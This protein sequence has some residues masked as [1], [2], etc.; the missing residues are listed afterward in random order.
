MN[1]STEAAETIQQAITLEPATIGSGCAEPLPVPPVQLCTHIMATGASCGCPAVKGTKL[2]F[3]HSS[4]KTA[5]GRVTPIDQ[6]P[7]GI[8]SPIPFVFAED[9]ASLHINFQLLL[10]AVAEKRVDQRTGILLHRILRSMADNLKNPLIAE[11]PAAHGEGDKI[12]NLNGQ[13]EAEMQPATASQPAANAVPASEP[14]SETPAA[15][16]RRSQQKMKRRP[17]EDS[18]L[19]AAIDALSPENQKAVSRMLAEKGY[20]TEH[21]LGYFALPPFDKGDIKPEPWMPNPL[22]PEVQRVIALLSERP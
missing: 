22:H 15:P 13:A 18:A 12:N 4:V 20:L 9:A 10:Q 6:V 14:V 8:F 1:A 19:K 2:C 11:S 5:L 21:E 17:E 3:H 16:V 7:Y